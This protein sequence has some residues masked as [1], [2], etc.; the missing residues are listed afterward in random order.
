MNDV[1]IEL[2]RQNIRDVILKN[3]NVQDLCMQKAEQMAAKAGAGYVAEERN[4][5]ERSGAAVYPAEKQAV[6]DN[7]SN[8]TLEKV[9]R[10]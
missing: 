4:Y 6:Y 8:N 9:I 2:N 1:K 5:P 7:L 10:S 3:Q